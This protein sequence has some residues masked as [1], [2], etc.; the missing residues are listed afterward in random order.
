MKNDKNVTLVCDLQ[1]GSTGKGL[2]AGYLAERDQ[3]DVVVTA[4]SPN[5]GHT[6]INSKGEKF[7]HTM[8]A[9]GI[10]SPRLKH[11]LIGPGSVVNMDSLLNEVTMA[12][13]K[14]YLE[15]VRILIHPHA[16]MV[17]QTHRDEEE[18]TMTSIG[19][20][21]KGS[22]A[23]L[24]DKIRRNPENSVVAKDY[25]LDLGWDYNGCVIKTAGFR[26]YND[27]IDNAEQILVE[28]AQGFS[29][30]INNG[31]Y[32]YT[33]SRECTPTQ[34]MT[35]CNVPISKLKT[36]V[37]CARTYPIRVSNRYNE[38]GDMIGWSG[39]G[40]NDQ[41]ELTWEQL[42]VEPEQTTVTKLT[43]RV[44]TFSMEQIDQAIRMCSPNEI[45]LNFCNYLDDCQ[46]VSNL[47]LDIHK[48]CGYYNLVSYLGEG[49]RSDSIYDIRIREGY[50]KW[51]SDRMT[52]DK[53]NS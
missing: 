4:W 30:G 35:D 9:N 42:G 37:G 36:V 6:Y 50:N 46:A 5:A 12:R 31:Y 25:S 16:A 32:P 3:P 29:L 48:T 49:P 15:D 33:T 7:V 23:A 43:R 14:G 26:Q 28:G 38:A 2:I 41:E 52:V 45:F 34:I 19:S 13:Q 18:K 8:L 44:F 11:V 51:M 47:V 10:V 27:I 1:F 40:Y 17:T 22:G 24:I 20:T 21:K 53:L 39:P